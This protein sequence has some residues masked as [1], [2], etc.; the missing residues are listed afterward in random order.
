MIRKRLNLRGRIQGVGFRPFVYRLARDLGLAGCVYN[1]SSGVTI[2]IQGPAESVNRFKARLLEELPPLAFIAQ[3]HEQDIAASATDKFVIVPSQSAAGRSAVITPDAAVCEDCLKELFDPHDRRYQY[4]FINCTNCGPRYSIVCRV[5]YDRPNTTMARF[6]LCPACRAEYENPA[7]RRFHAQPNACPQCGPRLKL[8]GA[9]GEEINGDPVERTVDIIA[10]GGIV[11][12]KGIGGYHLACS[13]VQHETV[14]RL[15]EKKLRDSKPFALMVHDLETAKK[16]CKLSEADGQA[17]ASPACPIVLAPKRAGTSISTA[18]APD[19]NTLGIMLP[20]APIHSLLFARNTGPLVMTSGNRSDEPLTHLDDDAFDRLASMCD[21]LLT[22]DREIHHPIDD[23]VVFTFRDRVVP[24]RRARG[25]APEPLLLHTSTDR[26]I[27]AVGGELKSTVCLYKGNE[28]IV[29]EHLGDLKTGSTLR[30]YRRTVEYLE[31]MFN[32]SPTHVAA[33]LHPQYLSTQ[34]ARDTGLEVIGVQHHHAHIVSCLADCGYDNPVIGVSCDGTGFGTD[35]AIWGC[36][37]LYC[38][39]T[40]F[41]RVGHLDYFPLPGGDAAARQTYRPAAA[42]VRQAF[43]AQWRE[44]GSQ[45]FEHVDGKT[46]DLID[47]MIAA[48]INTPQTSS[49]GRLFDGV[50]FLLGLCEEN[51]HE[52]RA[53][54]ALEAACMEGVQEPYPYSILSHAE[55]YLLCVRE[56]IRRI[57]HDRRRGIDAGMMAARFHETIAR[58]LADTAAAAAHRRELDVVAL[59]GGCFANRRLLR[60]TVELLEAESLRVL[61]HQRVPPGDGG[62]ALGQAVAAAARL[63]RKL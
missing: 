8:V 28:A 24:I 13:A 10:D 36:E 34:F 41:D 44:A 37:I 52:G 53:A 3:C 6:K 15:R 55:P 56:M 42:L 47:R 16:L 48:G 14:V 7:D 59:S 57:V 11:A 25:F 40:S 18:V 4:P 17:L 12:I 1:H 19:T 54:I 58:M 63:K 35:G 2:E 23:S 9:D 29:S 33:D 49:L 45:H 60:R 21:A 46:L 31:S 61:T 27:L 32:L 30:H 39:E 43:G 26:T 38:D 22:H 20:Y 62:L 5:P 51:R 50:S